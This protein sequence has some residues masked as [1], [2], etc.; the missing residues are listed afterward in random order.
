MSTPS[1]N[2]DRWAQLRFMIV[3]RLFSEPPEPGD[4]FHRL[5]ELANK[6]WRHPVTG[7]EIRF[8]VST[9]ERW[10][11]QALKA[12]DPVAALKN[13][14]GSHRGTFPSLGLEVREQLCS[15]YQEHPGWT[16][17]LHYDNL[18]S[19]NRETGL[20]VPS[21]PTIL[22]FLRARG[23]QRVQR[24]R[25]QTEGERIALERLE[26]L[27][28][29]SYEV[30][31]VQGLWHLDF[32]HGSRPVLLKSGEWVKPILLGILDDRS[33]LVCHLQWYLDE[34]AEHL[35]HGLSQA[36]MKRGLPRALM[37]DNGAAMVAGETV[38]GLEDLG[39]L[40]QR[41]L[42][43]SAYQN[44]KQEY[45]WSRVESRLMAMLEGEE[46]LTLKSLNLATQ[47]WVEQEYNRTPHSE[48]KATPLERYLQGPS[49]SRPSP[50]SEDLADAF[51]LKASRRQRRS[52][53][54]V[55]LE[56]QRFEVPGRYRHLELAHLRYARWDL[57]HV[58]LVDP[59]EGQTLCPI[60]P[61]DKA[62]NASGQRKRLEPRDTVP[63]S[64]NP[65]TMAPLLKEL[66]ADY[67]ASGLPP[68]YLPIAEEDP[69]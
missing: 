2:R 25:R 1:S 5:L 20:V 8:G 62:A 11:Y 22:R 9:L 65:S 27:E 53:G 69:A 33:R 26:R 48:I 49:V 31:Y 23:M 50:S 28:V 54:T 36:I 38:Q 56:G 4:L 41:I 67:A 21:Y 45:L 68:A 43:Y 6:T 16:V 57:G 47:A 24:P 30:E 3:G 52:D 40:H 34:T 18:V 32:H 63:L 60:R 44:G 10:Y 58:D 61:I 46:N 15:Q 37:T 51:R 64:S 55:A 12:P 39:I 14:P 13:R 29:R 7:G 59:I 66:I 35:V 17:K 42:P 19:L